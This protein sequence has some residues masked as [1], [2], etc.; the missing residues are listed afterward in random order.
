M[1]AL[2]AN[3]RF[4]NGYANSPTNIFPDWFDATGIT[5]FSLDNENALST[6]IPDADAFFSTADLNIVSDGRV[7]WS[8]G[9]TL[10]TLSGSGVEGL[11]ELETENISAALDEGVNNGQL[12]NFSV[13]YDDEEL[14]RFGVTS[15]GVKI[16][17]GNQ[18]ANLIGATPT[19][20]DALGETFDVFERFSGLF[21]E[22]D[23]ERGSAL[24]FFDQQDLSG[25]VIKNGEEEVLSASLSDTS[26]S[27]SAGG[28]TF[29]LAGVDLP[30]TSLGSMMDAGVRVIADNLRD[31][32][33]GLDLSM[34]AGLDIT[35]L[36][37]MTLTVGQDEYASLIGTITDFDAPMLDSVTVNTQPITEGDSW[38][39]LSPYDRDLVEGADIVVN[40]DV[41]SM[42]LDLGVA[43][44]DV[45]G[46]ASLENYF[47]SFTFNPSEDAHNYLR[48]GFSDPD[49]YWLEVNQSL[50]YSNITTDI[51]LATGDFSITDA[52]SDM[53]VDFSIPGLEWMGL[54]IAGALNVT[55]TDD[56]NSVSLDYLPRHLNWTWVRA[57]MA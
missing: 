27:M 33:G 53:V 5:G 28:A 20:F 7:E 13:A 9:S 56:H 34:F 36:S 31:D 15:N 18:S 4:L 49:G 42:G 57:W 3:L 25:L 32:F 37:E 16:T 29:E 52:T 8:L 50:D 21:S 1:G 45:D 39:S 23:D 19:G 48:F 54:T 17:T 10:V 51:N 55:G 40:G 44:T 47:N 46:I 41:D 6:A 26:F 12:T 35:S 14:V 43:I 11:S 30:N 38:F 24:A 2:T 22:N